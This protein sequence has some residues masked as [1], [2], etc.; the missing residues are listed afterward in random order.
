MVL[1][2]HFIQEEK[3]NQAHT[4]HA[5]ALIAVKNF[6]EAEKTLQEILRKI[7]EQKAFYDLGYRSLMDYAISALGL[8]SDVAYNHCTVA[9]KSQVLPEVRKAVAEGVLTVSAVRHLAPILTPDNQRE[10]I[11]LGKNLTQTELRREVAK[12]NPEMGEVPEK[13]RYVKEDRLVLEL[14]VSEKLM[15]KLRRAQDLVSQSRRKLATLEETLEAMAEGFLEKRD[16][17]RKAERARKK[18]S[19]AAAETG[20]ESEPVSEAEFR[21]PFSRIIRKKEE[22]LTSARRT[23]LPAAIRHS[24]LLKFGG[25]CS[26]TDKTGQRCNQRRWLH[27]HHL[28]PVSEGGLNRAENLTLLCSGHHRMVHRK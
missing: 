25:Q 9:K 10:L 23:A 12:R 4:L 27:F 22:T 19:V 5:Q 26:H 3:M 24:V 14:R 6:K 15:K 11:E 20:T 17:L 21:L 28:K 1:N 16:P 8:S 2:P 18:N 7:D 13:A